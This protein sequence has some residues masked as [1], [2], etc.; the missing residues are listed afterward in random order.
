[1]EGLTTS[2]VAELLIKEGFRDDVV[3]LFVE[4]KVDGKALMMLETDETVCMKVGITNVSDKLK[5][6]NFIEKYKEGANTKEILPADHHERKSVRK[7]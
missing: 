6:Y 7:W 3:Q 5:L 4:N 2:Q 1:M